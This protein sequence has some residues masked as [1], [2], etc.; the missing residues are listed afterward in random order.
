MRFLNL[1]SLRA[2]FLMA[3]I[4]AIFLT[5]AL[6]FASSYIIDQ[7]KNVFQKIHEQNLPQIGEL[8]RLS[9]LITD[10]QT[11]LTQL[12]LSA[13]DNPDEEQVYVGGRIILNK[14][15]DL[16]EELRSSIGEA[17]EQE[18]NALQQGFD[19][20]RQTVINAIEIST[21]DANLAQQKL[22]SAAE[23]MKHLNQLFLKLSNAH[24]EQLHNDSALVENSLYDYQWVP[25][26]A[27]GLLILMVLLT[28]YFADRVTSGLDK[29]NTVLKKLSVGD[30]TAQ[31]PQFEDPYLKS[32]GDAVGKFKD[33]LQENQHHK[34]SLEQTVME[35]E[36]N[37]N[38]YFTVL[39]LTAT[40]IVT[41][42]NEQKIIL[43][44][45]AAE[46]IFGYDAEEI[47]G[48]PIDVLIPS[49]YHMHHAMNINAFSR[50][51]DQNHIETPQ[52][53]PLEAVRKNGEVFVAEI[54]I[55]KMTLASETLMTAAI[56][57]ITERR[58]S[59]EKIWH[60]AHFDSLTELPNRQ[61]VLD[62]LKQ[63]IYESERQTEKVAVIFI[64]LDD[65]KKINDSLG[66]NVG[67]QLLIEASN[68]LTSQLRKEDTVGRLGGDEFI[69]LLGG[70]KKRGRHCVCS[71]RPVR[72]VPQAFF[73]RWPRALFNRQYWHSTLS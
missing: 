39:D 50:A 3:H 49:E 60:Q 31:L 6:F 69:V 20:C 12:L 54:D 63:L 67:D 13:I 51:H 29:I 7:H 1:F 14:L 17:Y 44:N 37:K 19:A 53:Q 68:R 4:L 21:V 8:S 9:I 36:D 45:K 15:H 48:Q 61:L 25:S 27:V 5:I 16:E 33:V 73:D 64:D 65:F 57:D 66:H 40:A 2:R 52:K 59:E 41:I 24:I 34:E 46:S 38:R 43:F 58:R 72:K 30:M 47:I 56:T 70:L 55:A 71:R 35:L 10:N 18:F 26:L 32:L 42:D 11:L 28:L 22:Q 23:S 62:R